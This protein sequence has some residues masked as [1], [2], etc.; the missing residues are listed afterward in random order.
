MKIGILIEEH[1]DQTEF[2]AFNRFF[3]E[4]GLEVEYL[5]HLWG[6]PELTFGSN[7]DDGTVAEHVTVRAEVA[8]ADPADYA[9]IVLMGAYAMDRLRYQ[10]EIAGPKAKNRAPAVEFLRRAVATPQLRIGTICH[11]LWLFC[12]DP[13]LIR[14]RRVTCA[15]NIVCDVENAG[16]IVEFSGT[17]TADV[18]IDGNLVSARHSGLMDRFLETFLAE[19]TSA[20]PVRS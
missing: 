14:G 6:Y 13:D 20:V 3:P 1:F 10:E 11:S 15:H 12:A 2:R 9:G 17:S 8:T 7:P 4:H 18:V 16:G 19:I 5:T